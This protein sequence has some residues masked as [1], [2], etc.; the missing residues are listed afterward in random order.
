MISKKQ[1]VFPLLFMLLC[2]YVHGQ[3]FFPSNFIHLVTDETGQGNK[4][5]ILN[6]VYL[7]KKGFNRINDTLYV[8]PLSHEKLVLHA[9]YTG[10]ESLIQV[11]YFL[12]HSLDQFRLSLQNQDL[13]LQKVNEN[14]YQSVADQYNIHF[15]L[16]TGQTVG[17]KKMNAIVF[18]FKFK[19]GTRIN[20]SSQYNFPVSGLY[21]FQ[22]TKWF[23]TIEYQKSAK[24][25]DETDLYIRLSKEKTPNTIEFLNDLEFSA[26]YLDKNGKPQTLSGTYNNGQTIAFQTRYPTKSKTIKYKDGKTVRTEEVLPAPLPVY[27]SAGLNKL[28]NTAAYFHVFFNQSYQVAQYQ[29]CLLLTGKLYDGNPGINSRPNNDH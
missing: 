8:H 29:N 17:G 15:L 19:N 9:I 2:G 11:S 18:N 27:N 10:N 20:S 23:F 4:P 5:V 16:K 1:I 25:G 22:H 12:N 7:K 28:K 13:Q 14:H 24:Y 3:E 21:P 6:E 26:T